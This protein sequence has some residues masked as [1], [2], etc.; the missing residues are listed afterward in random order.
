MWE[1]KWIVKNGTASP[2][3]SQ[4]NNSKLLRVSDIIDFTNGKGDLSALR[5]SL[6][7]DTRDANLGI[8]LSK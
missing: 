6:D 3:P 8:P 5:D 7:Q 4:V 2:M 1:D